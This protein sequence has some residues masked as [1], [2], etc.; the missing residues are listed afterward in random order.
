M[1]GAV[2]VLWPGDKHKDCPRKLLPNYR[3]SLRALRY[4]RVSYRRFAVNRHSELYL[5]I[6]LSNGYFRL[7][8]SRACSDVKI[9]P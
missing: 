6:M 3:F 5:R 4:H 7:E 8:T 1:L 2:E 9:L